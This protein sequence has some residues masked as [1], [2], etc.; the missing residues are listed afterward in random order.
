[1]AG[2]WVAG[3]K[4]MVGSA[5][6]RRL[7]ALGRDVLTVDKSEVDLLGFDAVLQW[8]RANKPE[9][10]VVA[11]ARVGGILAN[12]TRP[13]E[14]LYENLAIAANLIHAAHLADVD[15]LLFL[16]SSCIYPKFAPQPIVESSLMTGPL[17]PT[18]EAYAIAKI[19]GVKLVQ[20]YR[21]QYGRRYI[22]L[23]PCNLYGPHDNF[24]PVSSHVLAALI[25]K[26]HA[27]KVSGAPEAVVWGTGTPLRE[28]LHVDDLADAVAFCLDRYDAP[29]PINCGAGVDISI[30][31]LARLVAETV[32]FRGRLRFDPSKPDGTP[33]KLMDSNRLAALG[34]RACI[35]LPAGLRAT[36]EW[37]LEH[38]GRAAPNR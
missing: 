20:A 24:D 27:A 7:V 1:M 34:W 9:T 13:A 21:K 18:N 17:E 38:A 5:V 22:S 36:Y 16:G 15:R 12:D 26:F 14:F 4:G 29:E 6:T 35:A 32:G 28:F 11:A 3:H 23:M 10:I 19:A 25:A 33:R 31:E 30:G 37:F 2:V 8:L